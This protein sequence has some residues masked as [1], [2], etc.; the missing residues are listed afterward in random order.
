MAK[1]P[2]TSGFT[3]DSEVEV[4]DPIAAAPAENDWS[5]AAV[6]ASATSPAISGYRSVVVEQIVDGASVLS[7]Y[8]DGADLYYRVNPEVDFGD[9]TGVLTLGVTVRCDG[10]G[11]F[12]LA[13]EGV[14]VGGGE[15]A[16]AG[17][18]LAYQRGAR[19]ILI[20]G[21]TDEDRAKLSVWFDS[22]KTPKDV[23]ISF[24]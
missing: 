11:G 18:N 19:E 7:G 5:K 1:A 16:Y 13:N 14:R 15:P 23:K 12:C 3:D 10:N 17:A 22:R 9:A 24:A 21:A 4:L 8:L 2:R 20:V 6:I